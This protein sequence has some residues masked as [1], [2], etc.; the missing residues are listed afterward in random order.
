VLEL[1]PEPPAVQPGTAA[2]LEAGFAGASARAKMP[3]APVASGVPGPAEGSA[4]A[5]A[6]PEPAAPRPT[7]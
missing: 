2:A 5:S 4:G 7:N 3:G 1:P 6:G